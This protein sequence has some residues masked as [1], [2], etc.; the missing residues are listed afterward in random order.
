MQNDSIGLFV[1]IFVP[2]LALV[3]LNDLFTCFRKS[4]FNVVTSFNALMSIWFDC[5]MS[6]FFAVLEHCAP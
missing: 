1:L 6:K 4:N 3:K 5:V 2:N